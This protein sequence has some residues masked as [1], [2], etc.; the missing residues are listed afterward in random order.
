MFVVRTVV[1]TILLLVSALVSAAGYV[2]KNHYL[3]PIMIDI[4][5]HKY[6]EAMAKLEPYAEKGDAQ[7]L[8]WYGYMKQS[9]WGRDRFSA[10]RWYEKSIEGGNPYSMFKLSGEDGTDYVCE[11]NGWE[12]SEENLD[13]ALERWKDLAEKGDARAEYYYW[14]YNR[15]FFKVGFDAWLTDNNQEVIIKAASKGYYRPLARSAGIARRMKKD[16]RERWGS[17][18]Y[19]VLLDSI[20]KDP[21]IAMHFVH[22]PYEGMTKEERRGLYIDSLKKGYGGR[23]YDWAIRDDLI[24]AEEAYVFNRAKHIGT[25]EDFDEDF[26]VVKFKI[27]EKKISELNKESDEFFNSIEQVI[28][29]DEM[30]FMY[31]SKPDV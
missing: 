15:S 20:D 24:S 23:R 22:N 26:Y 1:S 28:N 29:F 7:A 30:E 21:E 2:D 9:N 19:Q 18:M 25:G 17:E 10:Y 31:F 8:F 16:Y 13:K 14:F 27:E 5:Y 4:R 3:Y 11:V 12:C 6:D